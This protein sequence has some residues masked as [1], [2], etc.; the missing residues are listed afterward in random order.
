MFK[1]R[2]NKPTVLKRLVQLHLA[3]K[4]TITKSTRRTTT[5]TTITTTTTTT[6]SNVEKMDFLNDTDN[7]SVIEDINLL[8]KT[9]DV[10]TKISLISNYN[11]EDKIWLS[12]RD[13][14]FF[15]WV[16]KQRFASFNGLCDPIPNALKDYAGNYKNHYFIF[17]NKIHWVLFAHVDNTWILYDNLNSHPSSYLEFFKIMM[18]NSEQVVVFQE[19]VQEQNGSND[20]GLFVCG[21]LTC[22]AFEIKPKNYIFDQSS[23][24]KHFIDCIRSQEVSLFPGK[25]RSNKVRGKNKKFSLNLN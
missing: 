9:V 1:K 7:D 4:K 24:R 13:I 21:F 25:I 18:P 8:N 6:T 12:N 19:N 17:S 2:S 20:C 10:E 15:T 5:T 23:M 16:F 3:K 14:N 11:L 22:L